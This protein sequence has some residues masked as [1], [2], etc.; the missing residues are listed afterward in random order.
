M[1]VAYITT[2]DSNDI[3]Q[4]S[5]LGYYMC[6]CL[7]DQNVEVILVNCDVPYSPWLKLKAKTILTL[8]GKIY[9]R[10]RDHGYLKQVAAIAEQKLKNINYDL[11]LS[12]G[13]LAITYINSKKPIVFWTDAT[14]DGLVGFYPAWKNL[15]R[16]TIINGN[17]AEQ[18]AINKASL[19]FYTSEWAI[20]SAKNR[21]GATS[22]KLMQI[23][24]G[25]NFEGH[26]SVSDIEELISK[27]LSNKIINLLFIGVEWERKGGEHAVET[28][29][30]LRNRGINATLTIAGC[31]PPRKYQHVPYIEFYPFISKETE[32]GIHKLNR[33][34]QKATFFV[35][36]TKAD[37]FPVVFSEACSYG[38]PIITSNVGGCL[39]AV[40]EDVNGYCLDNRQF[41]ESAAEKIVAVLQSPEKYHMLSVNS[42]DQF[43]TKLNWKVI[44]TKAVEQMSNLIKY[45][46]S[47]PAYQTDK[48]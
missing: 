6:K 45:S 40:I 12:P 13:S 37:C 26:Q 29:V 2:Y 19:I 11:I 47:V 3:N 24:F 43:K 8:S 34:Y 42:F 15:S 7:S 18:I 20:N 28:V 32:N 27:R 4:W 36:P 44:G 21:Y 17:L 5:G 41:P 16:Q 39:S 22:K 25:S 30:E 1:T 48:V 10:D 9:Q 46:G 38:L 35:L 14:Y 31:Y 33:L 23:P